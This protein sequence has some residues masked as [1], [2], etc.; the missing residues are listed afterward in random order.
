MPAVQVEPGARLGEGGDGSWA[1]GVN[2]SDRKLGSAMQLASGWSSRM[3]E[4]NALRSHLLEHPQVIN[5][6]H[7]RIFNIIFRVSVP[8]ALRGPPQAATEML[9]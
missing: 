3:S 4:A 9:D 6:G 7:V 1:P 5:H 2:T 8:I